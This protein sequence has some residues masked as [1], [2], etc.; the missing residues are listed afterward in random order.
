MRNLENET[1]VSEPFAVAVCMLFKLK[2]LLCKAVVRYIILLF[3]IL[4]KC[5]GIEEDFKNEFKEITQCY[6]PFAQSY[7]SILMALF[8]PVPA[9]EF[10]KVSSSNVLHNN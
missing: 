9:V 8:T 5:F 4:Q 1:E 6:L 3:Y 10:N 7:N 2:I